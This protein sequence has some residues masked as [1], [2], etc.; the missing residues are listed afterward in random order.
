MSD[1]ELRSLTSSNTIIRLWAY[2]EKTWDN[3]V[4]ELAHCFCKWHLKF[5][6]QF[7]LGTNGKSKAVQI[8]YTHTVQ[9]IYVLTACIPTPKSICVF[10]R[11]ILTLVIHKIQICFFILREG[12]VW[13]EKSC[14]YFTL[15]HNSINSKFSEIVNLLKMKIT[16]FLK[17][18]PVVPFFFLTL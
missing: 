3:L 9:D 6:E 16:C 15:K 18:E 4:E 17:A 5:R 1:W 8:N 14:F 13:V 10:Y 11:L 7:K 12:G 2:S